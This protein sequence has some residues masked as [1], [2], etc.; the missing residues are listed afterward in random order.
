M[1]AIPQVMIS[2]TFFDLKQVRAD[3]AKFITDEM[4]CTA[5]LSEWPSFP[6]D[7]DADTIENCRRRVELEADILILVIGGRFGSVDSSSARSITNL[8]YLTARAKGIPIYAFVDRQVLTLLSVWKANKDGDFSTV[9][10][11]PRIFSFLEE[12]RDLH[13]VWVGEF[14]FAADI[15][16]A[17]RSHFA[18]LMLQGAQLV[19]RARSEQE[20]S[21]LRTLRGAPLRIALEKPP[22]WEIRLFAETLL[23]ELEARKTLR[24]QKN[25][26][27]TYGVREWIKVSEIGSWSGARLAEL[28]SLVHALQRLVHEELSRAQGPRGLPGDLE[29]IVFTAQSIATVY[30]EAIEWINRVR[31]VAGDP[32]VKSVA[33]KMDRFADDVLEKI[34]ALGVLFLSEADDLVRASKQGDPVGARAIKLTLGLPG[35]D[36]FVASVEQI[37][38]DLQTTRT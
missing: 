4:G 10:D 13:R 35:I 11:D 3:L 9:V 34:E 25:I 26:A 14:E 17:V 29:L 12:V 22:G 31:R 38:R 8:E 24:H 1:S 20:Y 33:T 5:L 21:V 16:A 32:I 28:M 23:Q 6:I 27:I 2:S 37:V 18:S 36:N 15:V 7:P 19:Q 30:Q